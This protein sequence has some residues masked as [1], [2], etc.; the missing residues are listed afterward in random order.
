[1][2]IVS[3]IGEVINAD[4]VFAFSIVHG[5]DPTGVEGDLLVCQGQQ[6]TTVLVAGQTR[7]RAEQA[8]ALVRKA[9]K[10]NWRALDLADKIGQRPD[11]KIAVPKLHIP[12]GQ[13]GQQ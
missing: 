2:F 9:V 1:M 12:N 11:M 8:L 10:E 6:W 13:L 4:N 7:D 5:K 3:D